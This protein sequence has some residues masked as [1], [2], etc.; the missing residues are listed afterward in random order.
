[1]QKVLRRT[2]LAKGQARRKAEKE[3]QIKAINLHRYIKRQQKPLNA[4]HRDAVRA[5]RKVQREDWTL[6]ALAPKRDVGDDVHKYGT[7]SVRR[8]Q[9]PV[10]KGEGWWKDYGIVEGDRVVIVEPGHRDR[11]KIGT[12]RDLKMEAESCVVQGLNE[13]RALLYLSFYIVFSKLNRVRYLRASD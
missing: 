9:P 13:V 5:A 2:H 4:E 8:L 12:V 3:K 10:E 7:V 1:M 11:G 6:G